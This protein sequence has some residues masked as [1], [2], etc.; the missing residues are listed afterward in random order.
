MKWCLE[1]WGVVMTLAAASAFADLYVP[2]E[3]LWK[4]V[5]DTV[6]LQE[7][8]RQVKT[9]KPVLAVAVHGAV[10][11]VGTEEGLFALDGESLIRNP[12]G[13]VGA[14]RKL[15]VLGDTLY[16]ITPEALW[17][18]REGSWTKVAQGAY[19]D[20]CL[21]QDRL[22]RAGGQ[23]LETD[24][25]TNG[26]PRSR[27]G[28]GVAG[29]A[30]YAETVY[31]HDGRRV[32]LVEMGRPNRDD[33]ADWGT[34]PENAEIRD[35]MAFGSRLLVA[36]HKGVAVL[37][38]MAWTTLT[39]SDGLPYEDTTCL[40]RGFDGDYWI[41]TTRGAIR[42]VGEEFHYFAGARWLPGERVH[43]IASGDRAVYVATDGGLGIITYEPYT[44]LKKAAWY[45]RW[46]EEWGQKRLGFTHKLEWD[47]EAKAWVREISDN[48]AGWST[49]YLAA[50][51]FKYAVTKDPEARAEA[52]N[53]FDTLKWCEEITGIPGFPARSIWAVG[54]KGH[55]AQHGSGGLP[56][57][58]HLTA[59]KRWEWKGDTSSDES[60]AHYYG[61]VIF[62]EL[63]AQGEEKARAVEHI[64]RMTDHIIDNGWVLRD[65]DGEPTRWGRWDPEYLQRPQG[66][67]ARGLNGLEA[68][69]FVNTAFA[70]TGQEK[71][72]QARRQLVEWGY[73]QEV[74][75]QKLT[76]PPGFIFHSDDRLAFYAYF[77]LLN[78]SEE[79]EFRAI[80]RR[81]LERSWEVERIEG[82][83]WFNFIYGA[84]TG[85]DCEEQQAVRHLREWPLD[86]V[87]HVFQNSHR[88]D[89]ATP[90]GYVNYCGGSKPI[91]PRERGPQRWTDSTLSLDGGSGREVVDPAGWLDAYWMGR[92]YGFIE[93]PETDD[94]ALTTV[95]RRELHLGAAPYNG[96][97]RPSR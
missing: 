72:S 87:N 6:Y 1:G 85:N 50:Q 21:N 90:K 78:Y 23:G 22:V 42:A 53:F 5:K 29:V 56:A 34:L 32:G 19:T 11:Y 31:F 58:W 80:Y 27:R 33:V 94:P 57:E 44:L 20:V 26:E 95:E 28:P 37:R 12:N 51:C 82:N 48:D 75:R 36:T 68:L 24:L 52:V 30:S 54:E 3:K 73:H 74:L 41:G 89:L 14:V 35:M 93:A 10:V 70:L 61:T 91:S 97:S 65:Y 67:Y 64:V 8:G 4:P 83:P 45:E 59:D 81:S 49:H 25:G 77:T 60:D 66:M 47:D 79:P 16:A 2:K 38:G 63:A 15:K 88:H 69:S 17:A 18:M 84:L 55:Q 76:F 40:A 62:Y 86:C 7:V 9:P 46:L 43:A 13:P 71:Y 39:G 92:Y 96:P